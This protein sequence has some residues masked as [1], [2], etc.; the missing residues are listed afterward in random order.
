MNRMP[1][2][3][4]SLCFCILI[5]LSIVPAGLAYEK[6]ESCRINLSSWITDPQNRSYAEMML[7][8]YVR[9]DE[10]VQDALLG[11]FSAVFLFDG[12]SDNMNDPELS[13]ISYYRVSGVCVVLRLNEDGQVELAYFNDSCS[14]I[15]DRPLEIGAWYLAEAGKVGPATI[16]DGT[17]QLYSIRHKGRYEALNARTEYFDKL[18]D[19]VYMTRDG[20]VTSRASEINVHTR[21]TNHILTT[22]MWSAGCPLVGSG[23]AWEYWKLMESVYYP[24]FDEFDIEQFVG[25]L[26]IDRQELRRELYQLYGNPDA[27][28][29]F[30]E[31]STA[32]QPFAYLTQCKTVKECDSDE[33]LISVGKANMMTLPCTNTEDARSLLRAAIPDGTQLKALQILTN[34]QGRRWYKVSWDGRNGYVEASSVRK[35]TWLSGLFSDRQKP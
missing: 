32:A 29:A 26:T 5:L 15:P 19:A 1:V 8:H 17:Y 28:D 35:A 6:G 34:V 20:F 2:R 7:D 25:T 4:L 13:D 14:T 27:V 22:S 11:G 10:M 12:C 9:T 23:K 18:L 30:L 3:F 21:T 16:C 24:I 31:N 33:T